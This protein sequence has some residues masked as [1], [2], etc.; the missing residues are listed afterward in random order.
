[1]WALIILTETFLKFNK[2]LQNFKIDHGRLLNHSSPL[3][4]AN[5]NT[6]TGQ[7]HRC[8]THTNTGIPQRLDVSVREFQVQNRGQSGQIGMNLTPLEAART[9]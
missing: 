8:V 9:S 5:G 7:E 2:S 3:H 1:M 4:L 6:F